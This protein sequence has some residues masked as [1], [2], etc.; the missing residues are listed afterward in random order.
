MWNARRSL[1]LS[2]WCVILFGILVV[3]LLAASPWAIDWLLVLGYLRQPAPYCRIGFFL[4]FFVGAPFCLFL[5]Y[6]LYR[7]L[8]NIERDVIFT[9]KNV[10]YMRR[11]SW[12]SLFGGLIAL[13]SS[14]YWA[15]WLAVA[16]AA[17]F[18]GLVARVFKNVMA[19]ATALKEE[20]D[21]T[22]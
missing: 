2:K 12:A 16:V 20:N 14:L 8:W 7:L 11:I 22:I 1:L 9:E 17:A 4:T 10:A 13:A 19:Q 3:A 5:L 15:P 21:Y 6:S 18:M